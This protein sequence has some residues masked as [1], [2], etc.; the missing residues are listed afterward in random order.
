MKPTPTKGS[1]AIRAPGNSSPPG[2]PESE[3][4]H[5]VKKE[6]RRL[7]TDFFENLTEP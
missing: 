1:F 7:V 6:F 3:G 5:R 4:F 2:A